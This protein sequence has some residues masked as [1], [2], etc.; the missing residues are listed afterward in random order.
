MTRSKC[1]FYATSKFDSFNALWVFN[2]AAEY[3]SLKQAAE[4]LC[5]SSAVSQQIKNLEANLSILLFERQH[6]SSS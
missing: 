4:V 2:I 5:H 6:Q 1:S 3:K